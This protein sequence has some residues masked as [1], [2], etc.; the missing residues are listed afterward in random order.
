M[1][2]VYV[3]DHHDSFVYNLV[4]Y[5]HI[6]GHTT[7]V[8]PHHDLQL[9]DLAAN[10]PDAVLLSPGPGSPN[11]APHSLALVR[12]L[13]QTVPILGICLGHQIIGQAFGAQVVRAKRPLHGRGTPVFH[14][15]QGLFAAL[16]CPIT[17]ARYHSLAIEPKS[18]LD[19]PL[20]MTAWSEEQEV[21]AIQHTQYPVIGLQGH[22][23]SIC[24]PQGMALLQTCLHHMGLTPQTYATTP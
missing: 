18:L 21:M 7:L 2:T 23:E 9:S 6:L 4:R 17:M 15:Q 12:T 14:D 24:S 11:E 5:I 1:T 20:T 19:T 16:P 10:P 8:I 3:I 22:P 13:Y